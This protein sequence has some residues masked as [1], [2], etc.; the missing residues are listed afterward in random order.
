MWNL[1]NFY[2]QYSN[3]YGFINVYKAILTTRWD[4]TF[5]CNKLES[6]ELF[7]KFIQL[8]T[9]IVYVFCRILYEDTNNL[10]P[11]MKLVLIISSVTILSPRL[12]CASYNI[13][14]QVIPEPHWIHFVHSTQHWD[15]YI[16][17]CDNIMA[18]IKG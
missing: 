1:S 15:I 14:Y 9:S 7:R 3:A 11:N 6:N 18:T 13:Y 8:Y 4:N 17:K 10:Q 5:V 12:H 2:T 16:G